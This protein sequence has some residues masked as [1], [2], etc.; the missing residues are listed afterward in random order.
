MV[1][2][3]QTEYYS[4]QGQVTYA[5]RDEFGKPVGGLIFLGDCSQLETKVTVDRKEHNESQTG[6]GAVDAVFE[7]AQKVEFNGTFGGF[8]SKNLDLYLYGSSQELEPATVT[9]EEIIAYKGRRASLARM[10]ITFNGLGS[11]VEGEDYFVDL[12]TGMIRFPE[13]SS[14]TDEATFTVNYTAAPERLTTAFT[15][16]NSY[17]YLRFDGLNRGSDNQPVVIEVYRARFDP[18]EML[19]LIN[20]EFAEY[21]LN[22]TA[23]YDAANDIDPLYGGFMRVRVKQPVPVTL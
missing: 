19:A 18:A 12:S 9:G 2:A 10:P 6:R 23:L 3:E 16:L 5:E 15:T 13:T 1:L 11:L 22:G 8:D 7:T 20:E 21:T 4:G 14:V 17:K